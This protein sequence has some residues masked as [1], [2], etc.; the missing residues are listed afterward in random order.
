MVSVKNKRLLEMISRR[1]GRGKGYLYTSF[2]AF[3]E[4]DKYK[5]F[6]RV[7]IW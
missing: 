4:E 3:T 2:W 6:D 7:Y 5:F 1:T